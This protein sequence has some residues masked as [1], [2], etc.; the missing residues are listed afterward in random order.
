MEVKLLDINHPTMATIIINLKIM[1]K[2]D[3]K[4]ELKMETLMDIK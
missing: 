3:I 1:V 4:M 2:M